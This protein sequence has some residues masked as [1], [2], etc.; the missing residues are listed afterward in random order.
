MTRK[1]RRTAHQRS[2]K[3]TQFTSFLI[4]FILPSFLMIVLLFFFFI[5]RDFQFHAEEQKNTLDV[6]SSHLT[7][8]INSD[9]QLSL[10]YIFDN[11]ISY[12]YNFLSRTDMEED[13][14]AYNQHSQAYTKSVSRNMTLLSENILGFGFL[15]CNHNLGLY[16]YVPKYK[17]LEIHEMPDYQENDWYKILQE[18]NTSVVFTSSPDTS[19]DNILSIVRAA[20]NVDMKKTTGY[21]IVDVSMD[22]L[23]NLLDELSVSKNSG[24]ILL[25]PTGDFLFSTNDRLSKA[26]SVLSQDKDFLSL[27]GASYD[28][29]SYRDSAYGFTFYYLSSRRDLYA[30]FAGAFALILLFYAAMTT[31]AL[32][33]FR[34]NSQKISNSISPILETMD[35]YSSGNADSQCDTS[36]CSIAEFYTISENLNNMIREINHH[37]ENEYKLQIEQKVAEYQALQAEVD[38]HFL[39]NTLNLF[40][41]LNRIGAKAELEKTIVSL[42][43]LFRYTCEHT[44]DSTIG[45]E[46]SFITDYLYLQQIRFDDRLTFQIYIEPGLENFL[47]PKLLIQP[48]VENAIV[49]SLEPSGEAVSIQLTA[50]TVQNPNGYRFMIISVVNTGLPFLAKNVTKKRVGLKNIEQRLTL[51]HPDSFFVIG[52]GVDKPTKCY[53]M[54][55]MENT[56]EK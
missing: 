49:H 14:V 33:M 12:F 32:L 2:L 28:V 56:E 16:F 48:L 24:I 43:H 35:S 1:N 34:H 44:S 17:S 51:F 30:S 8:T 7:A 54:I 6:L 47:I 10:T 50:I 11:D 41:T 19:S 25:S 22:F 23:Y 13:L 36:R 52:G 53:I 37:I 45:K 15:P 27:D 20:K 38:P 21:I 39:Y 26:S 5:D 55:P 9:L 4:S 31:I 18:I 46:F 29:R 3:N 42:S 40:I